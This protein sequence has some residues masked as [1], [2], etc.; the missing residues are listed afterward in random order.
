MHRKFALVIGSALLSA[1]ALSVPSYAQEPKPPTM[2][3]PHD[4]SM[5]SDMM[6]RMSKMMDGCTTMM[7]SREM[8]HGMRHHHKG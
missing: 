6:A 2:T 3:A 7:E 8:Q 1:L 5:P 4:Q